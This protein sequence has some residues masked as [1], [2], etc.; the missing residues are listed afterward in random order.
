MGKENQNNNLEQYCRV[1]DPMIN[2]ILSLVKKGNPQTKKLGNDVADRVMEK[3]VNPFYMELGAT[4]EETSFAYQNQPPVVDR[5]VQTVVCPLYK[6]DPDLSPEVIE[7]LNQDSD[8]QQ[9]LEK[10]VRGEADLKVVQAK[11]SAIVPR[12]K[13]AQLRTQQVLSNYFLV[14]ETKTALTKKILEKKD[15]E[16]AKYWFKAVSGLNK[17][18]ASLSDQEYLKKLDVIYKKAVEISGDKELKDLYVKYEK[19]MDELYSDPD[20]LSFEKVDSKVV[21]EKDPKKVEESVSSV[22]VAGFKINNV[23]GNTAK[24]VLGDEFPVSI[25]VFRDVETKELIYRI[26]D[27]ALSAKYVVA[28]KENLSDVLDERYLD[29]K[30]GKIIKPFFLDSPVT[31]DELDDEIVVTFCEALIGNGKDWAYK[32]VENNLLVFERMV[33]LLGKSKI[34]NLEDE[35]IRL[36]NNFLN[37]K[38]KR[39][40]VHRFILSDAFKKVEDLQDFYEGVGRSTSFS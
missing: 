30:F 33:E 21:P 23:E 18:R 1:N 32:I 39:Q 4:L 37:T 29:A 22:S 24:V 31:V 2:T 40:S 3:S 9:S 5:Y 25:S 28:H 13:P 20:S 36:R 19:E 16:A 34:D 26:S 8:F 17:R 10:V 14:T 12:L 6:L 38:T 7:K 27:E 11:L 35:L 15:S